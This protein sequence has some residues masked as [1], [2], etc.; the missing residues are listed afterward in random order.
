MRFANIRE[1]KIETNK[2]IALSKSDG[3]VIITRHG[4]PV[5]LLRPINSQDLTLKATTV[6]N[7]VR[8][9]AERAGHK[10]ANIKRLI[11][12]TRAVKRGT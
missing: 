4:Q 2:V 7:S 12:E 11:R 10:A 9:S 5:V 8:K 3:P 1:L 6:W